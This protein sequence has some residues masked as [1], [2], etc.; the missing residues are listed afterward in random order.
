MELIDGGAAAVVLPLAAAAD[1][2][3]TE[4][5][6][7]GFARLSDADLLAEVRELGVLRRRPATAD[8][9]LVAELDRRGLAAILAMRNRSALLQG[10]LRLSPGEAG[11]R[12]ES[13]RACGPRQALTGE[14]LE[15]QLPTVAAAQAEGAVSVEHAHVILKTLQAFPPDLTVEEVTDAEHTLVELARQ[16]DPGG[17][18]GRYPVFGLPA[19]RWH[20]RL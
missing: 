1:S 3:L 20:P 4:V 5:G 8:H 7:G 16:P 15:P 13:A 12:V 17:R 9:V 6:D 10:L 14:T 18:Q 19:P 11:R 2:F